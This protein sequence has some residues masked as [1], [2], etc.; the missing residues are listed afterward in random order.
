MPLLGHVVDCFT[1]PSFP[2]PV[3]RCFTAFPLASN[4]NHNGSVFVQRCS[5]SRQTVRSAALSVSE[6]RTSYGESAGEA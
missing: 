1:P 6:N 5:T 4:A 2:N 3:R